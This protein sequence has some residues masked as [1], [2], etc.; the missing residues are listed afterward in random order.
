MAVP[1]IP[2]TEEHTGYTNPNLASL[3]LRSARQTSRHCRS[4]TS[5]A[6]PDASVEDGPFPTVGPHTFIGDGAPVP[7]LAIR[8]DRF[9]RG[10]WLGRRERDGFDGCHSNDDAAIVGLS[11]RPDAKRRPTSARTRIGDS[12]GAERSDA[13]GT[14]ARRKSCSGTSTSTMPRRT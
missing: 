11:N 5:K 7:A 2:V 1:R 10:R 8:E 9:D 4:I 12:S 13:S 3:T 14:S 6:E